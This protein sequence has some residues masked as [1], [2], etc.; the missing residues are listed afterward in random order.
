MVTEALVEG[1]DEGLAGPAERV[2]KSR[3]ALTGFGVVC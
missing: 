1:A 3:G 2:G